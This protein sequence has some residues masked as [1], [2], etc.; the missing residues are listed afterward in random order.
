MP[1]GEVDF[2]VSENKYCDSDHEVPVTGDSLK[3]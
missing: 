1:N 3:T 2:L